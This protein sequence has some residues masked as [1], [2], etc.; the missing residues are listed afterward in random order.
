MEFEPEV[1]QNYNGMCDS[2]RTIFHSFEHLE[3]ELATLPKSEKI[4]KD[5][6][7]IRDNVRELEYLFYRMLDVV[8][9]QQR[10]LKTLERIDFMQN[11]QLSRIQEAYEEFRKHHLPR[12][13]FS[14]NGKTK[15][16]WEKKPK[17]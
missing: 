15:V 13:H 4:E 11:L 5:L 3:G 1:Q 7:L 12:K 16:F 17:K 14:I 9:N 10:Q 8:E 6:E 2:T